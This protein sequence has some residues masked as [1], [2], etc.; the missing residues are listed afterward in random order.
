VLAAGGTAEEA[1]IAAALVS[2]TSYPTSQPTAYPTPVPT[3]YP[4]P[5]PTT[6]P[7]PY[8]TSAPTTAPTH[9]PTSHQGALSPVIQIGT[10]NTGRIGVT[11]SGDIAFQPMTCLVRS[12]FCHP[13]HNVNHHECVTAAGATQISQVVFKGS[14]ASAYLRTFSDGTMSFHSPSCINVEDNAS[15]MLMKSRMCPA[16][17]GFKG[18]GHICGDNNGVITIRANQVVTL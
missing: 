10:T 1:A 8:P 18:A 4:T 12:N 14:S 11:P 6:Y 16:K 9:V 2:P 17:L 7:T 13:D 5:S 15:N 3:T